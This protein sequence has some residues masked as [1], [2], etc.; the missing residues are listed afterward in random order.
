MEETMVT[1]FATTAAIAVAASVLIA[2]TAYAD[3]DQTYVAPYHPRPGATGVGVR[4][5][6][7]FCQAWT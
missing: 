4:L 7:H 3:S 6:W 1:P 5:L 2:G